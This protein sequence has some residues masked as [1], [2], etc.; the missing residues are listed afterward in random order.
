MTEPTTRRTLSVV[1]PVYWNADSI[2]LLGEKLAEL[3]QSLQALDLG[4]EV[5][6]IDDGSGDNSLARLL[7]L[8]GKRPGTKVLSLSRNFGSVAASKAGLRFV[9][10]DC[11]II[12][13]ADLQDPLEQVLEMA[14]HWRAGHRLVI[15]RRESRDDPFLTKAFAW[16]YYR[17]VRLLV[18]KDYPAGGFDLML[19]DRMLLPYLAGSGKHTNPTIYAFWLGFQ[20]VILPYHRRAREHGKSR[21]TF[22]KR[23]NFMIDSISG[24]SVVPIRLIS[25]FG[26]V[27]ALLSFMYGLNLIIQATLVRHV[28]Q[29]FYTL[30]TLIAFFSGLILVMLGVVG[31]YIWRIFDNVNAK[32]ESVIANAWTEPEDK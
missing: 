15:S 19:M 28:V 8:R 4:L 23:L 7:E 32:P 21:F 1:I 18:V 31:E 5:I 22:A 12:L 11:F 30:A 10:G 9:T 20:P 6:C 2:P 26:M 24:F 13:A 3:E 14:K 29:G 17:L 25:G 16:L 27:V